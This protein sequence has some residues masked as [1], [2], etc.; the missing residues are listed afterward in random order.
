[1][2]ENFIFS[3]DVMDSLLRTSIKII[4]AEEPINLGILNHKLCE[5]LSFTGKYEMPV[6]K[7]IDCQVPA[8]IAAMYRI[9]NHAVPSCCIPHFYTTDRNF[10]STWSTPYKCLEQLSRFPAV[11]S[12]DFSLYNELV[13]AQKVWNIFR[14][15]LLAAWWQ[16]NGISVISNVSWIHGYDYDLPFDGWPLNSVIAVNSTGIGRDRRCKHMWLEGYNEM[17]RR[18]RPLHILRYGVRIEGE[19]ADISTYYPNDNKTFAR[20]GRE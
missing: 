9:K 3:Q 6:V 2:K 7:P 19:R 14:N 12:T 20:H 1:M 8:A 16:Y 4:E 17:L 13:Y 15:K 11:I 18:L 5:V 10:E